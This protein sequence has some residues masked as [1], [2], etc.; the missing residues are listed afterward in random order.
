[1]A[2]TSKSTLTM[3]VSNVQDVGRVVDTA[4]ANGLIRVHWVNYDVRSPKWREKALREALADAR[5]KAEAM[6]AGGGRPLGRVVSVREKTEWQTS[7]ED[8]YYS[9][10]PS[11]WG[12]WDARLSSLPEAMPRTRALPGQRALTVQV[13]AVYQL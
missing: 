13:E 11:T 8:E 10:R 9:A 1:M 2:A 4:G 5:R 7:P 12:F 3:T 6:A